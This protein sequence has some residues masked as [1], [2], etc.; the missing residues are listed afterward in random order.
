MNEERVSLDTHET[1]EYLDRPLG[2]NV[3]YVHWVYSAEV[4]EFENVTS[5]KARLVA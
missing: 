5:F 2:K 3:I 1:M 4:D